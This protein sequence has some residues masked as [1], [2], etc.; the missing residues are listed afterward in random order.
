MK[1]V[2]GWAYPD[3]DVL[4]AAEM[5]D[6][7][8]YQGDHLD[9]ALAYVTDWSCALDGGAHVG[10]W[11]RILSQRFA[12]VVAF[13]PSLDTF[14]ALVAN[15]RA[16]GC[17]SVE[18]HHAALGAAPGQVSMALDPRERARQNTGGRYV[19]EGGTIPRVTID[20]LGLL[21]LGFLKLDVEGS[22]P[23]ALIGARET[24]ARCRPI[25]LYED[26]YHWRRYGLRPEA[27]ATILHQAGYHA[28]ARAGHDAIWGPAA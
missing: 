10:T 19:R 9:A 3:D 15:M 18:L 6:D 22:E 24:L 8:T 1:L 7:G 21:S 28:I 14:D 2:R 20:S 11:T 5:H 23:F 16:F 26:K 4:M 25:V 12:R 13:E 17:A 27:V